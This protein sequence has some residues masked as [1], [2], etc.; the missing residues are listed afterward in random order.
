[1]AVSIVPKSNCK[2]SAVV[3]SFAISFAA[4]IQKRKEKKIQ[5]KNVRDF[6]VNRKFYR[7]EDTKVYLQSI[8]SSSFF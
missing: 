7:H 6:T 4:M 2:D 5:R 3:I 1:V 8:H